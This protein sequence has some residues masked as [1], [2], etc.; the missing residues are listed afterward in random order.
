MDPATPEE[1]DHIVAE[2]MDD[3]GPGLM[4]MT[5]G[6]SWVAG[7]RPLTNAHVREY[8]RDP[9]EEIRRT[10]QAELKRRGLDDPWD[11]DLGDLDLSE[12][13]RAAVQ[14]V[15]RRKAWRDQVGFGRGAAERETTTRLAGD[16]FHPDNPRYSRF[17][18]IRKALREHED[19][20]RKAVAAEAIRKA[21]RGNKEDQR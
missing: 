8:A 4:V 13:D 17:E 14:A 5:N 15:Y 1:I 11:R 12:S 7:Q 3:Q 6:R 2:L 10:A 16:I 21:V 9:R 18:A 20:Q 19:I